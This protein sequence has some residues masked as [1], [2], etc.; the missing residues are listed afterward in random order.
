MG[1]GWRNSPSMS[2]VGEASPN[3]CNLIQNSNSNRKT[4]KM[5]VGREG[6]LGRENSTCKDLEAEGVRQGWQ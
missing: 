6:P 3:Q 1:P 2:A 4:I 5:L